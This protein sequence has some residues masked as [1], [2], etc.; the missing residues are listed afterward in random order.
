MS[1]GSITDEQAHL[2]LQD[3]AN[4][5]WVSLHYDS[6]ALGGVDKAEISGGGYSR[7]KMPFSQP[8]NRTIWSLTDARYTG[9][10]QN[11]IV[12]FGVWDALNKGMLRAYGE[13]PTPAV[14]L[15]GKGY[16]LHSGLL[17]ISFG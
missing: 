11:K 16:I 3:I 17:A 9:L 14:V 6:P 8:N 2:W 4:A 10:M 5:G 1:D 13:L 7:F 12:Y 15:N